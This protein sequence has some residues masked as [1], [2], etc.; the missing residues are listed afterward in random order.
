MNYYL[1]VYDRRAGSRLRFAEYPHQQR[2]EAVEERFRE[3]R[4]HR[5][6]SR[7]SRPGVAYRT[8]S[9]ELFA[10]RVRPTRA[11]DPGPV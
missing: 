7:S 5:T 9:P 3:E 8:P 11:Q 2:S 10:S 6:Q 1:L 4:K